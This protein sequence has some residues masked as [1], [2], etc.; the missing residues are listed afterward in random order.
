MSIIYKSRIIF[1]W[2]LSRLF[3]KFPCADNCNSWQH[4]ALFRSLQAVSDTAFSLLMPAWRID[5]K[6]IKPHRCLIP[7]N[8]FII[9]QK[10]KFE[11][12]SVFHTQNKQWPH[13]QSPMEISIRG[14]I[15][16][17]NKRNFAI[18]MER[19]SLLGAVMTWQGTLVISWKKVDLPWI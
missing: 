4:P 15:C 18:P 13:T 5:R 2:F 19:D 16:L 7:S 3:I 8:A 10:K 14:T 6:A 1:I 11:L 17:E 9:S 12:K